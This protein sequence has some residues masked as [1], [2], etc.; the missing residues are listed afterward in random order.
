MTEIEILSDKQRKASELPLPKGGSFLFTVRIKV[1][2]GKAT[3]TITGFQGQ[4]QNRGFFGDFE[5]T[6]VTNLSYFVLLR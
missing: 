1:E 3:N 4:G 2:N 6:L 5:F